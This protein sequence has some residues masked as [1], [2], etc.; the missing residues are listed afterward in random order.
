M[1]KLKHKLLPDGRQ[2]KLHVT[3]PMRKL[4]EIL[5]LIVIQCPWI[6]LERLPTK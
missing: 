3:E 5:V 6:S 4:P 2:R 1:L